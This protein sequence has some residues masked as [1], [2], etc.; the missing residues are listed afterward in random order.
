M[1]KKLVVLL[2]VLGVLLAG[3]NSE[4]ARTEHLAYLAFDPVLKPH[5]PR[6]YNSLVYST[7]LTTLEKLGPLAS[8]DQ[9]SI[10]PLLKPK[11][12]LFLLIPQPPVP[13]VP[14]HVVGVTRRGATV[15]FT[16][17]SG[18]AYLSGC[19]PTP[20]SLVA[21][22]ERSLPSGD[23]TVQVLDQAGSD[24]WMEF[25][26]QISTTM[27]CFDGQRVSDCVYVTSAQMSSGN[28]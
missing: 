3:C 6:P 23:F 22:A 9:A 8:S 10:A 15:K 14:E 25:S 4:P 18:T 11:S 1:L 2:G 16:L 26:E 20:V 12:V 17:R 7:S 21:V 28:Y 13:C 19:L 27:S 24:G 5:A